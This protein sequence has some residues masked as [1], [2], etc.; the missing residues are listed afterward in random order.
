VLTAFC[1][2]RSVTPFDSEKF[3]QHSQQL[4]DGPPSSATQR[5]IADA[6]SEAQNKAAEAKKAAQKLKKPKVRMKEL[7]GNGRTEMKRARFIVQR[8]AI[9]RNIDMEGDRV[10]DARRTYGERMRVEREKA[11]RVKNERAAHERAVSLV[12]GP[13]ALCTSS[14]A[15]KA[16]CGE[17]LTISVRLREQ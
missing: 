13:P 2:Q 3:S 4:E 16:D 8:L 12:F 11:E 15:E 10:R 5:R 17:S 9:D 1:P 6:V 7:K 14:L